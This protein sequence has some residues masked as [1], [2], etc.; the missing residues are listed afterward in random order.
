MFANTKNTTSIISKGKQKSTSISTEETKHRGIKKI[1]G[2]LGPVAKAPGFRGGRGEGSH[3]NKRSRLT[4][5][6]KQGR[7][8]RY[9]SSNIVH[10]G[11]YHL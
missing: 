11:H 2:P 6:E 10:G 1:P 3:N 5:F 9:K 8:K 7:I 4:R